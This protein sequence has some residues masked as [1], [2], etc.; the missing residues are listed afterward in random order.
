VGS[1]RLL[2]FLFFLGSWVQTTEA[3]KVWKVWAI[4]GQV[5]TIGWF[6]WYK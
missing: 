4:A 2:V 5:K 6:N 1:L 3:F